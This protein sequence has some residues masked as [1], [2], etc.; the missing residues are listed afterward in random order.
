[1]AQ[2]T[3][4]GRVVR[5]YSGLHFQPLKDF[6]RDTILDYETGVLVGSVDDGSPAAT[7]GIR[8]GDLIVRCNDED[9]SG[10]YLEDLPASRSTFAYLKC[11]EPAQIVV[12][13]QEQLIPVTLIPA[14][15]PA[16]TREGVELKDW[17]CTV[18]DI[19]QFRT[20][21]LA[22]YKPH[23]VYI[24]GVKRPGNARSSGLRGGDVILSVDNQPVAS[25]SGLQETYSILSRLDRG[26]RTTFI[27]ILRQGYRHS[28]VLDFNRDHKSFK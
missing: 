6:I 2:L 21:G 10:V 25:L 26:K 11:G 13:R 5:S 20:P 23:G 9:I 17:N 22:Y 8:A 15:K 18:Q 24:L 28:I 3:K 16:Q 14:E 7:A 12:Q 4:K 1:M 19:S 27:E